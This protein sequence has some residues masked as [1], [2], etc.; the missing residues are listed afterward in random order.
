MSSFLTPDYSYCKNSYSVYLSLVPFGISRHLRGCDQVSSE[1]LRL[2]LLLWGSLWDPWDLWIYCHTLGCT[3]SISRKNENKLEVNGFSLCHH[4]QQAT[5][6]FSRKELDFWASLIYILRKTNK[7]VKEL[8]LYRVASIQG[9]SGKKNLSSV[10]TWCCW[11]C[12]GLPSC[13]KMGPGTR[14]LSCDSVFWRLSASKRNCLDHVAVL[15]IIQ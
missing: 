9:T 3:D 5:G 6:I 11:M 14:G 15:L 4:R 12:P 13:G 8:A 7:W 1:V 2:T 10:V